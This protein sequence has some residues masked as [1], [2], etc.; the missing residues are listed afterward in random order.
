MIQSNKRKL[1]IYRYK[2]ISRAKALQYPFNFHPTI[3][4]Y[5]CR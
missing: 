3:E 4:D 1:Q 5:I 2:F